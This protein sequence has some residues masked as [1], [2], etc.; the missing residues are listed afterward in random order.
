[1]VWAGRAQMLAMLVPNAVRSVAASGAVAG[2]FQP[3]DGLS[4]QLGVWGAGQ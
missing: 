2:E 3:A 1:M 4:L